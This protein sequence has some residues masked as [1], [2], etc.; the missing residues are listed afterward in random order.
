MS[1]LKKGFTLTELLMVTVVV[2]VLITIA[3]PKYQIAMEKGRALEAIANAQALSD[4]ANAY[5]VMNG[6]SYG[7]SGSAI[8]AFA[9]R[10]GAV[11]QSKFFDD[12]E[13]DAHEW[14]FWV[15]FPR[16]GGK[17]NIQFVNFGGEVSNRYCS[18][19]V[20][21]CRAFGLSVFDGDSYDYL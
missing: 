14:V 15:S 3:V 10:V 21:Y 6:N 8:T 13:I 7:N 1:Y 9:Q 19:D 5:Y 2:G 18:G 12:P 16:K 20:R 17:Y 4:A 11:T